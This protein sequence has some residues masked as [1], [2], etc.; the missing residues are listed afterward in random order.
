MENILSCHNLIKSFGEL[1]AV[2]NISFEIRKKEIFGLLGPN[3]AGKSTTIS[4]LTGF[5]KPTSG[6]VRI[7]GEDLWANINK[8]KYVVGVVPQDLALYQTL[9]GR[10][11]LCF[12]AQLY[13]LKGNELNKKV[14]EVLE[15]VCLTEWADKPVEHYSGGMKRRLNIAVG[16]IHTP[17]ILFLDEPTVGVDPQSRNHIF[18]CIKLLVRNGMSILYTTHY[19]EEAETLCDRIA[20]IDQGQIIALDT[21]KNLLKLA[22]SETIEIIMVEN[23]S[24]GLLGLDS[25]SHI[26]NYKLIN[27]VLTVKVNDVAN[28]LKQ[29]METFVQKGIHVKAVQMPEN[30]LEK[31]FLQLTGKSLRD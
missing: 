28:A 11:N 14:D 31:V 22:N 18:E 26:Q 21:C 10:E 2:N 8:T 23:I 1:T 7:K 6:T 25:I 9:T 27:N 16:I 13:G 24:E 4:L 30:N 20:I 29:L 5:V 19:M 3:G 12:F 15:I 17:E